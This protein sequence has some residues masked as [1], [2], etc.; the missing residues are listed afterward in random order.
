MNL[1][2][3]I[4]VYNEKESIV[5]TIN[6]IKKSFLN[7]EISYEIIA[8]DDGSNDGSSEIIREN[9]KD[10]KVLRNRVNSGYGYSLK[11]GIKESLSQNIFITDADGTYPN[12]RMAEFYEI[13]TK[14]SLDMLVGARKRSHIPLIRRPAKAVL[15]LFASYISGFSIPDL[16]SGFR[17]FKKDIALRNLKIIPDGFSFTSTTTLVTFS[18]KFFIDYREIDYKIR[19]GNSKIRPIRDTINFFILVWKTVF[20]FSPLRFF[21]PLSLMIFLAGIAV[22]LY[23]FFYMD[24]VLDMTVLI[25]ILTSVQTFCM[26]LLAEL[27]VKRGK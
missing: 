22:F 5:S 27:I 11:R 16:N 24:K 17:I 18:E 19:E 21:L 20:Y 25:T 15:R 7:K 4:P 10:V 2:I 3:L 1:T 12:E 26:G 14:N 6:E 13:Y 9:F 23:S 8:I